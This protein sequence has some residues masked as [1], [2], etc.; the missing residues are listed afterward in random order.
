M[1]V[2]DASVAI[3]VL[4]DLPPH[5]DRVSPLLMNADAIAAPHLL[6]AEVGQ[7]L[8]R[9]VRSNRLPA[10]RA[11]EALDDLDALALHRFPHQPLLRRAFELRDNV[12]VHDA[13]Y[14]ALAEVLAATF[15]T[16]DAALARVPGC[17]ARVEVVAD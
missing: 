12:T 10:R 15:V 3:D 7:V 9:L 5:A 13:L 14:L 8:R 6:D 17:T 16:R 2:V 1:I 11:E 4:L